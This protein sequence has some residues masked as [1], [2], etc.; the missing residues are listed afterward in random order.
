MKQKINRAEKSV[1]IKGKTV[2]LVEDNKDLSNLVKEALV[3]EGISVLEAGNG[4]EGI[5]IALSAH[6]DL[7]VLDIILPD[8]D[9]ISVLERLREDSWGK[10]ARVIILTNLSNSE[11]VSA[12]VEKGVFDFLVKE[13][14]K[15]SDVV[16]RIK[17]RLV[18]Q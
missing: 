13:E 2:L 4:N 1:N 9:G 14:W 7:V 3:Q 18:E 11:R 16:S 5:R 8:I 6:P 17:E 10:N 15:L 12:S